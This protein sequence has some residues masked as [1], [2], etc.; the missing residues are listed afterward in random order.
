MEIATE[1][2]A[3]RRAARQVARHLGF[4]LST[5]L[6]LAM[7]CTTATPSISS[8]STQ[9][10]GQ[11]LPTTDGSS[12][13]R[14]VGSP[15]VGS[16]VS[17]AVA[18]QLTGVS[19]QV[20][21]LA[22]GSRD[23]LVGIEDGWIDV[24]NLGAAQDD[25]S[26]RTGLMHPVSTLSPDGSLTATWDGTQYIEV[27]DSFSGNDLAGIALGDSPG[28]V[29]TASMGLSSNGVLATTDTFSGT[30][31]LWDARKGT[32]I[33][34]LTSRG[35]AVVQTVAISP[36]GSTV[37]GTDVKGATYLWNTGSHSIT[38]TLRNPSGDALKLD[39]ISF[40]P[41]NDGMLAVTIND[42]TYLWNAI[43]QS[44]VASFP[45]SRFLAL[46]PDGRLIAES[47]GGN[48]VDLVDPASGNVI[49]VYS[50]PDGNT[51][52]A[53][54]IGA[55]GKLAVADVSGSVSV[56]SSSSLPADIS[57]RVVWIRGEVLR[58]A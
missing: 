20:G 18:R 9:A 5:V 27:W 35:G 33:G 54:A 57:F 23:K 10:A 49:R 38:A 8:S 11:A 45:S 43:N 14:D 50:I 3:R 47:G 25:P 52:T 24:W 36:D 51:P 1:A 34:I 17:M 42:T 39:G 7:G 13:P 26:R 46:S 2:G 44:V 15:G 55:D 4:V 48:D 6:V 29:Q 41:A 58:A 22:F 56:W 28:V 37:A 19:G 40:S 53:A 30:I 21:G 16:S 31:D 12:S 32:H